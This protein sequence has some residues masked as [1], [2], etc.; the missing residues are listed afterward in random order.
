MVIYMA[1]P[2]KEETMETVSVRLPKPMIEE[3][4]SFI[5]DIKQEMPLLNIGRADGIRQLIAEGIQ[6]RKKK[7]KSN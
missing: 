5:D 6:A 7:N 1:R 2:K 3:I 4:D